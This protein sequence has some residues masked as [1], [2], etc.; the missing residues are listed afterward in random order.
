MLPAGTVSGAPKVRAMEII[1]ELEPTMRGPY[2]GAV[3]YFSYNGNADFAITIR[4]LV[5]NGDKTEVL[6][7]YPEAGEEPLRAKASGP[8]KVKLVP[9]KW[10]TDGSGRLPSTDAGTLAYY[11]DYLYAMYPVTDVQI[12][13][14]DPFPWAAPVVADG[15]GWGRG[16]SPA[17][18]PHPSPERRRSFSRAGTDASGPGRG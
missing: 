18:P 1:D 6:A 8:L 13:V 11:R 17:S 4:T 9:V 3:G 16:G 12:S 15:D 14:R 2:A 5:A 10:D 7:S